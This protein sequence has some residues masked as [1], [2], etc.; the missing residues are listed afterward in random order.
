MLTKPIYI[1]VLCKDVYNDVM[2]NLRWKYIE[3]KIK[4][5]TTIPTQR[6]RTYALLCSY[7]TVRSNPGSATDSHTLTGVEDSGNHYVE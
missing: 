4:G 5:R 1:H 2:P 3:A 7:A 6:P